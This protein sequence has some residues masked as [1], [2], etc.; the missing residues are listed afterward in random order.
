MTRARAGLW[1]ILA[2]AALLLGALLGLFIHP[3]PAPPLAQLERSENLPSHIGPGPQFCGRPG[4]AIGQRG[5][6]VIELT[7]DGRQRCLVVHPQSE[8][9]RHR[10]ENLAPTTPLRALHSGAAVW[11]V[12]SPEGVLV[13]YATR[14]AE[15]QAAVAR[16]G[17]RQASFFCLGAVALGVG[18]SLRSRA[19]ARARASAP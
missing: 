6:W 1:L 9:E 4:P 5:S 13:D 12:E 15:A 18:F 10:F 11:Q 16:H 2:G 19:R 8:A 17:L 7:L 3:D 14:R